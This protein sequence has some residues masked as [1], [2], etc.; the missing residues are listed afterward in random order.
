MVD[1]AVCDTTFSDNNNENMV[2]ITCL[3]IWCPKKDAHL[4]SDLLE[5]KLKGL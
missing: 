2:G 5:I 3:L 4:E 1:I